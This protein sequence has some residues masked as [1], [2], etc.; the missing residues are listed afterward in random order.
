MTLLCIFLM[1]ERPNILLMSLNV[2]TTRDGGLF[3]M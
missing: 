3:G 1:V 2:M